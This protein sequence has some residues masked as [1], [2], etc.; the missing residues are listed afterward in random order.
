M[1][2]E[3]GIY[4]ECAGAK[5]LWEAMSTAEEIVGLGERACTKPEWLPGALTVNG[6]GPIRQPGEQ[7][8]ATTETCPK[9]HAFID[10]D[11]R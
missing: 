2:L 10:Y 11:T 7:D 6:G 1:W 5:F 3:S 9:L 4:S 8:I